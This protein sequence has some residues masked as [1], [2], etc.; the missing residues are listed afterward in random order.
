MWSWHVVV[1]VDS[2]IDEHVWCMR[3]WD[4]VVHCWS[5]VIERVCRMRSRDVVVII[6]SN[7]D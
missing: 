6:V 1:S 3:G 4:V 5:C 7:I 2:N